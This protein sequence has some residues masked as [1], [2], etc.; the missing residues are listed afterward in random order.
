M[1]SGNLNSALG[2]AGAI[3]HK[4]VMRLFHVGPEQNVTRVPVRDDTSRWI[5]RAALGVTVRLIS[6]RERRPLWRGRRRGSDFRRAIAF[7]LP[8]AAVFLAFVVYPAPASRH[9]LST[10]TRA[11]L[12]SLVSRETTVRPWCSAVAAIMRSGCE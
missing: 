6:D 4:P 11:L 8:Y 12:K 5:L 1:Q 9:G 7:V 2:F 3:F 10:G